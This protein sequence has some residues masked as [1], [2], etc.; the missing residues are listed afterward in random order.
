[1]HLDGTARSRSR[2]SRIV[3]RWSEFRFGY[4][5]ADGDHRNRLLAFRIDLSGYLEARHNLAVLRRQLGSV[6]S[7]CW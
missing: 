4:V 1:M 2:E 6:W 5:V 3:T 7:G